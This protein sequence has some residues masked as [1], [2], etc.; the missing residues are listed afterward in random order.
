MSRL[1]MAANW[2][3]SRAP[4][5]S[6]RSVRFPARPHASGGGP[7]AQTATGELAAARDRLPACQLPQ[8][9]HE[10]NPQPADRAGENPTQTRLK[11]MQYRSSLLE[12]SLASTGL[13]LAPL[14]TSKIEIVR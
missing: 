8:Y 9:A 3:G 12:A 2:C 10:L 14:V 11:R 5:P 4:C 6:E 7:R 13:D 1:T